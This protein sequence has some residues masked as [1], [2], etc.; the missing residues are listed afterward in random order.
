MLSAAIAR[1]LIL[2]RLFVRAGFNALPILGTRQPESPLLLLPLSEA[3]TLPSLCCSSSCSKAPSYPFQAHVPLQIYFP[4]GT[5]CFS[6]SNLLVFPRQQHVVSCAPTWPTP[7]TLHFLLRP[8]RKDSL[9]EI[10]IFYCWGWSLAGVFPS[11]PVLP[12]TLFPSTGCFVVNSMQ[13]L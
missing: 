1:S 13:T 12:R 4:T 2:S 10:S 5:F 9:G 7:W 11:I 3:F 6:G 8:V